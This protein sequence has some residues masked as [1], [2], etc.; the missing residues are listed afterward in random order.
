MA[1]PTGARS[2]AAWSSRWRVISCIYR[3]SLPEG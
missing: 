2:T 3:R 1:I